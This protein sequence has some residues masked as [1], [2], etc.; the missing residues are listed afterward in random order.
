VA[1][2]DQD[3][4]EDAPQSELSLALGRRLRAVRKERGLT[5]EDVHR[6]SHGRWSTSVVSSYERG[7]RN[8]SVARLR[9]LA[10]FYGV[11]MSL[12][13]GEAEPPARSATGLPKVVLDLEALERAVDARP[14]MRYV[15]RIILE[16]GDFNGRVLSIR[17]DDI[18]VLCAIHQVSET[19]LLAD[20]T[21]WGALVSS[22]AEDR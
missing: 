7:F 4:D 13:V 9:E 17:T 14:I 19:Q 12:L 6:I 20:L 2:R 8:P 22:S 16:R 3:D 5:L 11:P 18:P 1:G 10:A 21:G 15:Q